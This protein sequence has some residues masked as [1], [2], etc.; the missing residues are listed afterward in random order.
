MAVVPI[1]KFECLRSINYH[2]IDVKNVTIIPYIVRYVSYS[3]PAT[4]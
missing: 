2:V 4:L 1:G 3:A